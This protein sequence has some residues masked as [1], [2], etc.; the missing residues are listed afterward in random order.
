MVINIG[1][2]DKN[3]E[4]FDIIENIVVVKKENGNYEI[5]KIYIDDEKLYRVGMS[6]IKI[7]YGKS[8]KT[9]DEYL[10]IRK[11]DKVFKITYNNISIKKKNGDIEVYTINE[12][13]DGIYL[14]KDILKIG[15][16]KKIVSVLDEDSDIEIITL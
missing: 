11:S 4:I 6:S 2:K 3:D 7:V 8:N 1:L 16:G 13:D 5:M 14:G 10:Y 15:N 12:K 9:E